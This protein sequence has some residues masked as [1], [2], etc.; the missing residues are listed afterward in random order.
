VASSTLATSHPHNIGSTC[1]GQLS[2]ASERIPAS[3]P[4]QASCTAASGQT[5][6]VAAKRVVKQK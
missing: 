6:I 5:G 4:V 3:E 2:D 1:D